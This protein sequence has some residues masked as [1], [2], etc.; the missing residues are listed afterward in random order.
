MGNLA[1]FIVEASPSSDGGYDTTPGAGLTLSLEAPSGV[2]NR[3]TVSVYDPANSGSPLATK[4]APLLTLVGATSSSEV[5]A[6]TPSAAV[7]VAIPGDSI[8]ASWKVRSTV[9]G[10]VDA[11]GQPNA[12]YVFERI[13]SVRT[14]TGIRKII[15]DESTEY[16][17]TGVADAQNEAADIA[18]EPGPPGA[19]GVGRAAVR[20][21]QTA[22]LPT[23]VRDTV[24]HTLT[25]S[26]NGALPNTVF[27]GIGPTSTVPLTATD[28]LL[29]NSL[30]AAS[31][32]NG[33]WQAT[34]F[35][36]AGTKWV[37]TRA[38]DLDS[39]A[40]FVGG[41]AADVLDGTS[42]NGTNLGAQK[43]SR[44]MMTTLGVV[45]LDTTPTTFANVTGKQVQF[46]LP[47]IYGITSGSGVDA[48]PSIVQFARDVIAA[49][50][51]GAGIKAVGTFPPGGIV[52]SQTPWS[53]GAYTQLD[54]NGCTLQ[55]GINSAGW[56]GVAGRT[57]PCTYYGG[58]I[59]T[60]A[61]A[62]PLYMYD[63]AAPSGGNGPWFNL[64][65]DGLWFRTP[66]VFGQ[67]DVGWGAFEILFNIHVVALPT[68]PG[69]QDHLMSIRGRRTNGDPVDTMFLMLAGT[70]GTLNTTIRLKDITKGVFG[71]IST[72]AGS[73]TSTVTGDSAHTP[74][75]DRPL[76]VRFPSGA[77][78]GVAGATYQYSFDGGASWIPDLPLPLG[79][80]NS[81]TIWDPIPP[82][83]ALTN[84]GTIVA[85]DLASPVNIA[86]LS[87]E[88]LV[89]TVMT[90]GSLVMLPFQ[91]TSSTGGI[92]RTGSGA[93][94][95][96]SG[97]S[98]DADMV[99]GREYFVIGG[100]TL[101]GSDWQQYSGTTIAGSKLFY[102]GGQHFHARFNLGAGTI[103]PGYQFACTTSGVYSTHVLNNAAALANGGDYEICLQYDGTTLSQYCSP[104]GAARVAPTTQAGTG[105]FFQKPGENFLIGHANNFGAQ[106][107]GSDRSALMFALG[108]LRISDSSIAA[109]PTTTRTTIPTNTV[110]QRFNLTPQST[111]GLTFLD[112]VN[113]PFA[114]AT[115]NTRNSGLFGVL[116]VRRNTDIAFP[117]HMGVSNGRFD[118]NTVNTGGLLVLQ[119]VRGS[120]G[121]L[122]FTGGDNGL[123]IVGP[124]FFGSLGAMQAS[125][126]KKN[127]IMSNC[128][129]QSHGDW[130]IDHG[131]IQYVNVASCALTHSGSIFINTGDETRVPISFDLQQTTEVQFVLDDEECIGSPRPTENCRV[132]MVAGSS[133]RLSGQ[134]GAGLSTVAVTIVGAAGGFDCT[135]ALK[136]PALSVP[137]FVILDATAPTIDCGPGFSFGP[138]KSLCDREGKVRLFKGGSL[139]GANIANVSPQT[140]SY[141]GG[142]RVIP[143]GLTT[144]PTVLNLA[145]NNEP[146][147]SKIT[148]EVELQSVPIEWHD[149]ATGSL[150][151][152]VP[153]GFQGHVSFMRGS[154]Q[155]WKRCVA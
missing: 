92:W 24:A 149:A 9:N 51:P 135:G 96:P 47:K 32:D 154:T 54:L 144:N 152:S 86:T 77:T 36:S 151:R 137:T 44:W 80:A 90:S 10:G 73:S 7:T 125:T 25:G 113:N 84:G 3:W 30:G 97:Y 69:G 108:C 58:V 16:S 136:L 88:Q 8:A 79:T 33:I 12:D 131:L 21:V 94:T 39:T 66:S 28:R 23:Y 55:R 38:S 18:G 1:R 100:A 37:L 130:V 153:A 121:D 145:N 72:V 56:M 46:D 117:F 64:T 98:L 68:V 43:G 123:S 112:H 107:S 102:N 4:D 15:A 138:T 146:L 60:V 148:F 71:A 99:L 20:A 19:P 65:D 124:G 57:R 48:G 82:L 67:E 120:F 95:R 91:S 62:T 40:D 103:S 109:P 17:Q 133:V 14:S 129:V 132:N 116:H 35:G 141:S 41:V 128:A 78:V 85:V 134:I 45:T 49:G 27:D 42:I 143:A 139:D 63:T 11:N 59:D 22:A 74:T 76:Q 61:N 34:N 114:F 52:K 105:K 101:A 119:P 75:G 29:V 87:G 2:V 26:V 89:D 142:N 122:N 127:F 111:A 155:N 126:K 104:L 5:D 81:F 115:G 118:G 110:G 6:A 147:S 13:L 31:I 106:E 150:I 83:A 70:T 93:W 50:F 53:I 140:V